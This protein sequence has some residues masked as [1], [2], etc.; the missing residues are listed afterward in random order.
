M[1]KSN[2][3]TA[4]ALAGTIPFVACALLP[5]MGIRAIPPLGNLDAL[6]S[7]YGLA[8]ICFVAGTHWGQFLS[9][10][11]ANSLNL[12]VISNVIFLITWF[13]FIGPSLKLAIAIQIAAFLALLLVD[14]QMK[15]SADISAHYFGIRAAATGIAAASLLLILLS[16]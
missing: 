3:Y 7:S 10:R 5:I 13:G 12:F 15:A 8:I 16:P 9:G 2:H 1:Q 14:Y 11:S 4:L 6:A